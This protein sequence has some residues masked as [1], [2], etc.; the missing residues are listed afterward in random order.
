MGFKIF[1]PVVLLKSM[2]KKGQILNKNKEKRPRWNR[3]EV[4]MFKSRGNKKMVRAIIHM[5]T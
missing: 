2:D 5:P 4:G 3:K 1:R